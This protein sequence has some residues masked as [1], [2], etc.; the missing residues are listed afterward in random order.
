[1][2]SIIF[3][4][5]AA[6]GYGLS[7]PLY[8]L[9]IN[10]GANANHFIFVYACVLLCLFSL[11]PVNQSFFPDAKLAILL[12]LLSGTLCGIGFKFN[13]MALD[14]KE[15]TYISIVVGI[16]ASY[17]AISSFVEINS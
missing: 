11:A 15:K 2:K 13:V 14:L 10:N 5:I 17:P 6:L 8:K 4:Q 3:A 12:I 7:I 9:A 16:A 1:M